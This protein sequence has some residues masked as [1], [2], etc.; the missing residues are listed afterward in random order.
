MTEATLC[1]D[2]G[3]YEATVELQEGFGAVLCARCTTVALGILTAYDYP[4]T[5]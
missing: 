3:G 5:S 1:Q 4:E 2:C